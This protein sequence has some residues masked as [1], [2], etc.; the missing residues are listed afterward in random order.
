MR[1]TELIFDIEARQKAIKGM[2]KVYKAVSATIGAEGRIILIN[3]QGFPTYATKD[4]VTV[5]RNIALECPVQK[6]GADIIVSAADR[7]NQKSG[8][9]TS[10]TTVIAY[11]IVKE[12]F[13]YLASGVSANTLAKEIEEACYNVLDELKKLKRDVSTN[14]DIFHIA[15]IALNGDLE[16]S[17]LIK[18]AVE[19]VGRNGIITCQ[20]SKKLK[21]ELEIIEGMHL[22]T[23]PYMINF[24]NPATRECVLNDAYI[25]CY[26]GHLRNFLEIKNILDAIVRQS[27]KGIVRSVLIFVNE[28]NYD[29]IRDLLLNKEKGVLDNCLIRTPH[30]EDSARLEVLQDI[31]LY[32]GGKVIDEYAGSLH[33][34]SLD[35]LG[36]A[37]K[38]V[39]NKYATMIFD[40]EG[41]KG[42]IN[43]R[44]QLLKKDLKEEEDEA[45]KQRLQA[46][47]ARLT[48]GI[49][50]INVGGATE[51]E[52]TEKKYRVD[53]ALQSVRCAIQTG[54]VAG[55][56]VALLR[57][58]K[59]TVF[60][61]NYGAKI[62]S[63]ALSSP[64][65]AIIENAGE[66]S[67]I[68]IE[69]IKKSDSY[70]Y[71]YNVATKDFCDLYDEGII[72]AYKVIEEAVINAAS[73]AIIMIKTQGII[74]E[75]KEDDNAEK[76]NN[77][78]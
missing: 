20:K 60:V 49:A 74:Y 14:D 77:R 9:G 7:T 35:D 32:T 54:I 39:V 55:G 10:A 41:S 67:D 46:R 21:S 38:V 69:N 13:K 56:G 44:V 23:G 12:A 30:L 24:L 51:A 59:N 8:D 72:D 18:E 53:D 3:R 62:V 37:K 1:P 58:V 63:K 48:T 66:A 65:K 15:K 33:E 36:F 43:E 25:L 75:K 26:N 78:R 64:A 11:N 68:I 28:A 57:A 52:L 61:D 47:I 34:A 2:E 45:A 76:R 71:G 4:G 27:Q 50:I 5:A 42:D 29:P 17:R 19:K 70:F 73:A 40:A 22:K 6:C 16:I 31:A